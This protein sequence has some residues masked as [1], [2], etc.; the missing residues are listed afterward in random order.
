MKNEVIVVVPMVVIQAL[1]LDDE[2]VCN[3]YRI[4]HLGANQYVFGVYGL[5]ETLMDAGDRAGNTDDSLLSFEEFD[6]W[7]LIVIDGMKMVCEYG[8][9]SCN[10]LDAVDQRFL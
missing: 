6:I 1:Q 3:H 7:A 5:S 2:S 4:K 8:R 10:D 9:K